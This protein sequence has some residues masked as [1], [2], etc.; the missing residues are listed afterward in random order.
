MSPARLPARITIMGAGSSGGVPVAGLGWGRCDPG[1]PLNRRSRPSILV[2]VAERR[3]LIDTS[4]DLRN[5]LLAAGVT[6]LDGVIYTHGHADHL[7]GI[8]DL[9]GINRAM[10]APIPAYM[11]QSTL[12]HVEN[13]FAYVLAPLPERANGYYFKPALQPHLII[14]GQPFDAAGVRFETFDQDH[15]FSRTV[16]FR[17]GNFGYSTDLVRLPEHGF[18]VLAGIHTWIIGVFTDGEHRTH[19]N[20]NTALAWIERV[21]PARAILTHLGPDL[22][23]E[24]L[25]RTLPAHVEPAYDGM[26]VEVPPFD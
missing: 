19:V 18:D 14:P 24:N 16:G 20:V 26:T 1:N 2:D 6:H 11:D 17:V 7:H 4:P 21:K 12:T 23:Y 3:F 22:D 10:N 9:R 25:C 13:S 5:Q 8:D 15:G